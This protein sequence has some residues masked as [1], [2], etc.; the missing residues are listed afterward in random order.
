MIILYV[1]LV[2]AIVLLAWRINHPGDLRLNRRYLARYLK[3]A[4]GRGPVRLQTSKLAVDRPAGMSEERAYYNIAA[5]FADAS[6]RSVLVQVVYPL[7]ELHKEREQRNLPGSQDGGMMQGATELQ[8]DADVGAKLKED[9]FKDL[10]AEERVIAAK[11]AM[12]NAEVDHLRLLSI[13]GGIFPRL[14][15][16][17]EQ[18]L[19]TI[20]EPVGKQRL[21]DVWQ[22]LDTAARQTLLEQLL[23]DVA[24]LHSHHSGD[25]AAT[26]P[27]GPTHTERSIRESLYASLETGLAMATASIQQVLNAAEPLTNTAQ[28]ERGLRLTNASPR[29]FFVQSERVRSLNWAGLRRDVPALDVVELVC[30]PALG[31]SA[32]Q[33]DYF[34]AVYLEKLPQTNDAAPVAPTLQE[35]R[36][37]AIYFQLVLAGHLAIFQRGPNAASSKSPLDIKHWP[38]TSLSQ[39]ATKL[40]VHLQTDAELCALYEALVPVLEPLSK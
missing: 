33:E 17:D 3:D 19:I 6:R 30:D 22:E 40:L 36:R 39:I 31:L 24:T 12:V 14:I 1:I 20:T 2:V 8:S 37:L 26:L 38:A 15:A 25:L 11:V 5:E 4:Q 34:F 29:G 16:H 32:E 21:D 23:Q 10:A 7:E 18:R 27:P 35:V 28:L 13:Q 9:P